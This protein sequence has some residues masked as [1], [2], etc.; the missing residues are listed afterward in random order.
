MLLEISIFTRIVA[1]NVI[2]FSYQ[3]TSVRRELVCIKHK[4]YYEFYLRGSKKTGLKV[5]S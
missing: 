2:L 1:F 4:Q 5:S 3:Y